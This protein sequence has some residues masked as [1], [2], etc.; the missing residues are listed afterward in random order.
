MK[1]KLFENKTKYNKNIYDTFLKFHQNKYNTKYTINTL[2]I[3]ILLIFCMVVNFKCDNF[4]LGVLF[5]ISI[6]L[7]FAYR[8][9]NPIKTIKKERN[10]EKIRN[11]K[12]FIFIFYN[13]YF[14]ICDGKKKEK[15]RYWNLYKAFEDTSLIYLYI[16]KNYAFALDK[17]GFILGDYKDFMKFIKK[18][19]LFKI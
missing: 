8:I 4:A 16:N 11:E 3:T 5:L 15:V 19:I 12:E 1:D 10:S 2:I 9:Y 18:K 14:V 17:Q 7:L 13:R 6:I